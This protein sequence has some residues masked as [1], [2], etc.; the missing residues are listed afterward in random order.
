MKNMSFWLF[1]SEPEKWSW[2]DQLRKG[3]FGEPWDG[4]RN[5]QASNNMKSIKIDDIGFFI[6]SLRKRKLLE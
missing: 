6:I 1:K 2:D 3:L 5:F 4:V